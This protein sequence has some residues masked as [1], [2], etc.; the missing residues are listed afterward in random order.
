MENDMSQWE[1][2]EQVLDYDPSK[3]QDQN[4]GILDAFGNNGWELVSVVHVCD[5]HPDI[6]EYLYTF[7]RP[8]H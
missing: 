2:T 8:L 1:Y 5:I 3:G 7:K 4:K 6:K